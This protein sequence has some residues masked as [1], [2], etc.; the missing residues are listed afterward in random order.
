MRERDNLDNMHTFGGIRFKR[1]SSV[2]L[3]TGFVQIFVIKTQN[4]NKRRTYACE[5][6]FIYNVLATVYVR[7]MKSLAP[8][9]VDSPRIEL[10]KSVC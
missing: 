6:Q 5:R 8:Y 9:L 4:T 7:S 1:F 10:M 2:F 3:A